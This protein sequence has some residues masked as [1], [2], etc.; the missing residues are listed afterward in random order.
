MA[1]QIAFFEHT[2]QT[3]KILPLGCSTLEEFPPEDTWK[4]PNA[5]S[6]KCLDINLYEYQSDTD[7][8]I[9]PTR[10]IMLIAGGDRVYPCTF[11]ES[12][13]TTYDHTSRNILCYRLKNN[14]KKNKITI[15]KGTFLQE[16]LTFP[17]VSY[18]LVNLTLK[19][20]IEATRYFCE[21]LAENI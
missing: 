11:I 19:D 12:K 16:L 6:L 18:Q 7:I 3:I 15:T 9:Q 21:T 2:T 4:T 13:F 8:S 5:N 20:V 14:S 10:T 1:S 17:N